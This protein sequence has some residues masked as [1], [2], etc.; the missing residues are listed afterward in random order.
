MSPGFPWKGSDP[1][2]TWLPAICLQ[3]QEP[4]CSEGPGTGFRTEIGSM[5]AG[6][7]GDNLKELDGIDSGESR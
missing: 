6:G 5:V 2:T 1:T 7:C 3:A 4:R